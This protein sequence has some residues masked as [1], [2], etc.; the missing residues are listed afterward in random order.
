MQGLATSQEERLAKSAE[1]FAK[2]YEDLSAE[3]HKSFSASMETVLR[4]MRED[5]GKNMLEVKKGL[6][7]ELVRYRGEA[8]VK[9]QEWRDGARREIEAY[10]KSALAG[11][12]EIVYGVVNRAAKEIFGEA[13][14]L[15]HQQKMVLS[16]LERAKKEGFFH[17]N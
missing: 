8:D 9:L 6:E 1:K 11:I 14:D 2:G 7:Q 4:A 12:D 16:S 10:K 5:A 15:R 17:G 3:I 13:L